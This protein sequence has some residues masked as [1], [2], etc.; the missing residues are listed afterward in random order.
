MDIQAATRLAADAQMQAR[1][2]RGVDG[3]VFGAVAAE[4]E[5]VSVGLG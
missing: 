5:G 3:L 1:T 4:T 2:A